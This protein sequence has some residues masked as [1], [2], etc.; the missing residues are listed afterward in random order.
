MIGALVLDSDH[1]NNFGH[2]KGGKEFGKKP[3]S[4]TGC[5][6]YCEKKLE[7]KRSA[8]H[9]DLYVEQF[10]ESRQEKMKVFRGLGIFRQ[11][12]A[13]HTSEYAELTDEQRKEYE[14][15][16]T[17]RNV[18][19]GI[20]VSSQQAGTADDPLCQVLDPRVDDPMDVDMENGVR[21]TARGHPAAISG[22]TLS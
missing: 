13:R 3:K 11:L 22:S 16:A 18:S 7:E 2:L 20:S 21:V 19:I 6:V 5:D 8:K 4:I 14:N 15:E 1:F 17:K 9:P 12:K 10:D